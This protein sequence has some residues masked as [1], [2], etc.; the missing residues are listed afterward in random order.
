MKLNAEERAIGRKLRHAGE[1]LRNYERFV[2]DGFMIGLAEQI[3]KMQR[4]GAVTIERVGESVFARMTPA[5]LEAL[6]EER[7]Q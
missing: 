1:A 4:K 5:G 2:A 7:S 6:G 3:E